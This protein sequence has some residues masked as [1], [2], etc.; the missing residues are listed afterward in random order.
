[1]QID[2]ANV[3]IGAVPVLRNAKLRSPRKYR[4]ASKSPA[5]RESFFSARRAAAAAAPTVF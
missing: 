5:G 3:R 2:R 1:V 4:L